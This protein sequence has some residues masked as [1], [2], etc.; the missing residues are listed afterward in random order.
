MLCP[1][2]LAL[3]QLWSTSLLGLWILRRTLG[4]DVEDVSLL[5]SC[6]ECRPLDVIGREAHLLELEDLLLGD[7]DLDKINPIDYRLAE[8]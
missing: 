4:E 7:H 5:L 1:G 6:D 3:Q 8:C 2:W